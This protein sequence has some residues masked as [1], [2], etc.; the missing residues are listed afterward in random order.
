MLGALVSKGDPVGEVFF[1]ESVHLANDGRGFP[2][3]ARAAAA[4]LGAE[5]G[6]FA[7]GG[8]EEGVV[9]AEVGFDEADGEEGWFGVGGVLVVSVV[10]E[11]GGDEAGLLVVVVG[12]VGFEG[13]GC[14]EA[15]DGGRGDL[16]A[17]VVW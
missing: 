3:G 15:A 5:G 1:C 10:A 17:D 12:V 7:A 2:L 14:V 9:F 4:D 11:D 13:R 6:E 8:G 16:E